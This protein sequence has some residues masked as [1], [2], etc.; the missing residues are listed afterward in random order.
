MAKIS[1]SKK[2]KTVPVTELIK[3]IVSMHVAFYTLLCKYNLNIHVLNYGYNV[4]GP[5]STFDQDARV[6]PLLFFFSKGHLGIFNDHRESGPR[7]II[8]SEGHCSLTVPINTGV[9][10]PT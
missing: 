9:L 1:N 3:Y 5:M 7:F 8:S 2:K 10:G 6:K 4:Q